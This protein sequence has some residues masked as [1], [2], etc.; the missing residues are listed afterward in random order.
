MSIRS[1]AGQNSPPPGEVYRSVLFENRK[2][3]RVESIKQLPIMVVLEII[4]TSLAAPLVLLSVPQY[5]LTTSY[6]TTAP[7]ILVLQL[8][9][10]VAWCTI[11][12]PKFLSPLRHLPGPSVS[13]FLRQEAEAER[14]RVALS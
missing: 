12:W 10:Y 7:L 2:S 5:T 1:A 8:A 6:V 3:K 9:L 14:D 13:G 11:L 4:L